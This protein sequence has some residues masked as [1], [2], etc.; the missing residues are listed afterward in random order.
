LDEIRKARILE[1]ISKM[2]L[3]KIRTDNDLLIEN[4]LKRMS[5]KQVIEKIGLEKI[6]D[7]IGL[8]KIETV[9]RAQKIKK[10][11]KKL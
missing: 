5:V 3:N 8:E 4:V 6:I 2:K 11:K 1:K 7:E 9:L 10:L